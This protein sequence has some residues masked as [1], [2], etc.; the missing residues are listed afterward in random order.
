M[1]CLTFLEN[2]AYLLAFV[3]LIRSL[4]CLVDVCW[5]KWLDLTLYHF[6]LHTIC[7]QDYVYNPVSA[8]ANGSGIVN[9]KIAR[10][11]Q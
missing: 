11:Q 2:G 8:V 10:R 7:K 5:Q 3:L 4:I 1:R 9:G 6:K